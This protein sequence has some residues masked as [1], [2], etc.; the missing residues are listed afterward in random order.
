VFYDL[1]K[2]ESKT[3]LDEVDSA[4]M[5]AKGEK[6][7]VRRGRDYAIIEPKEGQKFDKKV[8]VSGLET[9]IDPAA[10]WRQLFTEA[11]RLE[12]DYFYD[13]NLHG[14]DWNEM[15]RRYGQLLKDAVTRWDVNYVIGELIG[16]LNSSH[17]YRGGGDV[18]AAPLRGMGYLGVDFS[19]ENGAYRIKHIV[20]AGAWDAEARSPLK[21][22]G[23]EVKEGD[24]LL[25]VDG[26]P[27][28]SKQEPYSV[29]QGLADKAVR[30][31]VNDQPTPKGAREVLVQTL[32]SET[33]L[34]HLA[35]IEKNR[36]QVETST[37]GRVGYVYVPDTG[38]PGQSELVRQFR[39]QFNKAGLIIDE[40]F[41]SGGQIPNRFV[42]ML[43]RK[44][45]NYWAVR[46]GP[47]WAWPQIAHNGPEAM[48]INGWSGS[49]GDCFPFYFRKFGLGPLI[50][51]RTWGGLIGISGTPGLIDG[52]IV[53]VPTFGIYST[54]GQWIIEGHGVDPDIAVVDDPGVMAKG[55]DPQ[56]ERAIAE[57]LE[58]LKKRPIEQV[59]KPKYPVRSG[60]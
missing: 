12:R 53:T 36:K 47:D 21:R 40:R 46:D 58:A 11:W 10:E 54:Q 35:W 27:L 2:R 6:I 55:H 34:R 5:A 9:M 59:K 8:P 60:K 20:D 15:R 30:V 50:G 33:R 25:A 1:E 56:L 41:N 48:L 43:G 7:L 49:G 28:D 16:E 31:T 45:I 57:V 22:P 32:A 23:I 44:V 26:I 19:L 37:Q 14:V 39:A 4:L 24:Y 3:I 38:Q 52:G 18:E 13:P 29:F 51:E 17:T 42:E